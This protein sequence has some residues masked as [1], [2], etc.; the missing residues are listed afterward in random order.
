MGNV[1]HALP[2][3]YSRRA[4]MEETG[5]FFQDRLDLDRMGIC[6]WSIGGVN[7]A[8]MCNRL[9]QFKAGINFDGTFNGI[10]A[11]DG[12]EK[13]FMIMKSEPQI[14]E[15][16]DDEFK[17]MVTMIEK[18][19]SDFI[20]H[21][22]HI[23]RIII[24]GA[25]HTNFSDQPLYDIDAAGSINTKRCHEIIMNLT[26]AFFDRYVLGKKDIDLNKLAESY[27]EILSKEF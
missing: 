25:R 9:E 19:E 20:S 24:L 15:N 22:E 26:K 17:K 5:G 1:F 6:G 12:V 4:R 14:P 10:I 21:S 11:Q 27:P 18:Y 23:F 3:S 8:Q 7:A 2:G 16:P 13:P